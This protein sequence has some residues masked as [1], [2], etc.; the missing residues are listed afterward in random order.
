MDFYSPLRYPGG[1]GRL[2]SYFKEVV[3]ENLL[4]DCV[5]VEPYTGGASVALSL[6]FN[7]YASRIVINDLDRSIFAFWNSVLNRTSELCDLVKKTPVTPHT[8]KIQKK[9]QKEKADCD[10]LDLGF[11][12]L[13]LNRTNRS[14]I[15]NAGMIGGYSQNGNWKLDAR[16][17]KEKLLFQIKRIAEYRNRIDLYNLD[18]VCL[19]KSLRKVLPENSLF[20]FDPPYFVQGQGL[21]FSHYAADDHS[22]V[23][24]EISKLWKQKW[25]VTYDDVLQIRQLY[26]DFRQTNYAL[27]YSAALHK[28]GNEVMVYSDNLSIP[29][30]SVSAF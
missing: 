27:S 13:F 20:Y 23:A 21:Y 9:I 29:A 10:L 11:S 16:Y 1:K 22:A 30:T 2:A 6:L 15:L 17:D 24:S 12:T 25:I 28:K 3:K 26:S 18:A 4:Y 5:Y 14:G 8:W 7:E 19:V